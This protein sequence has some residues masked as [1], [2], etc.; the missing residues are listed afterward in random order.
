MQ[1]P[2]ALRCA[3]ADYIW[4]RDPIDTAILFLFVLLLLQPLNQLSLY[5][6]SRLT[7]AR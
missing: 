2:T 3:I 6:L 1:N 4:Q 5:L 7:D